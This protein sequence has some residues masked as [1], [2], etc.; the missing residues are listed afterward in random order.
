M[1]Y[2]I[3]GGRLS[4]ADSDYKM[5]EKPKET[6]GKVMFKT[7]EMRRQMIGDN[8]GNIRKEIWNTKHQNKRH[9]EQI[10]DTR[11]DDS[12]ERTPGQVIE[13]KEHQDR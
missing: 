6:P 11:T 1:L 4:A 8:S 7:D 10:R 9:K 2:F 3:S 12:V 13:Q 5:I